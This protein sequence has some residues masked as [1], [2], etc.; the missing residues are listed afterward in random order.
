MLIHGSRALLRRNTIIA[1]VAVLALWQ[2]RSVFYSASSSAEWARLERLMNRGASPDRYPASNASFDWSG[3]RHMH[4]I[5]GSKPLP[6]GDRR[7]IPRVQH[8]FGRESANAARARTQRLL[9]VR[10]EFE[11]S[12][13]GYKKFAW[14][15]DALLPLSG[16]AKDQFSGWA[17]TLVDS[18]DALWIMG[19]REEF[20]EAVAAVADIDFGT[21]S[22]RRIN[23][24]ET[25]IR[26]LGGLMAA[27]DLSHR[28]VL[29]TKAVE[30]GN[31]IYAGFNTDNG[32]PVDFLDFEAAKHGKG[33]FPE[34][35][36]VSASPGTLSLE[37]A[38]LSQLTG[39]PKY[40][41]AVSRVMDLFY[42]GQNKTKIPGMWP[43]T[44]S[45]SR[46]DVTS[47]NTFTLGGNA[48][49][50]Y[51]Y[52][53]KMHQLLGGGD[54][55][56]E[57]MSKFFL[58][59]VDQHFLFRP[60][61]PDGE[62]IL[63]PG[64]VNI[65][66]TEKPVLD[67]ETEHLACFVG[68]MYGLAGRLFNKPAHVDT[69]VRLTN[70]CVFAYRAFPTGMMP[71]RLDMAPCRDPSHCPWDE[72]Y[73]VQQRLRR[74][75]WEKHLPKGFTTA[76]DPR[77]LLRPE[78]IESVFYMYRLTGQTEFQDAA[79]D[80]FTA[81]RNGTRTEYANAAVLDVTRGDYPLPQEDYMESFWL[82][83]TLKYFYLVFSPPDI[84]SLDDFVLNTEAH[85][86]RILK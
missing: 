82:A 16:G 49:S 86:F 66:Y 27:Y 69:G 58:K 51:E 22:S 34:G 10:E 83:E 76:K 11:R 15:Q 72:D 5:G 47:G 81:I 42:E 53:P 32:M 12:W 79:W 30:L 78:A 8:R 73:W 80:M 85:P 77:Y 45:M 7:A 50:L 60:M 56:Y 62:D 44:V 28:D 57:F 84:I 2:L 46:M 17:A 25:N 75:E 40:Y 63:M 20:D 23:I 55:K 68:G 71:E 4:P 59:T 38:H 41:N 24:F 14:K 67:P 39:D 29:L 3:V 19:L 65:D 26:Y 35:H 36:V 48:D 43:M 21:S 18:L 61:L 9:E 52:L 13:K 33:L 74:P 54:I 70:G 37:L 64:N 6:E 1:L 31:L